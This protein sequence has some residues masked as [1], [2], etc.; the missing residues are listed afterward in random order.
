MTSLKDKIVCITG[1]SSGIGA[2]CAAEFAKLGCALFLSARRKDR[3][4]ALAEQLREKH[5]VRVYTARLDVRVQAQVDGVFE[6]APPEWRP[7]DILINNAGLARG[8]SPLQ[9]G[10]IEDWEEMIDTNVKGLLYVTRRILPG[11]VKRNSGHI[12]NIGSIAGHQ[13]YPSGNVY[14]ASKYAVKALSNGLR[15]DLLGSQVRVTSL[16]PGLVETE[17][18]VVRFHGDKD[19]AAKTYANMRPLRAEDIAEIAAFCA[20]RPAHVDIAEVIIMPTDQASA[21]HVHRKA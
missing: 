10:S 11:M 9:E 15:L 14:C 8:L 16:D 6:G 18:S 3:V 20:L 7:I 4:D 19:R 13:T 2:A 17:F 5:G 1:A 12:I 21:S